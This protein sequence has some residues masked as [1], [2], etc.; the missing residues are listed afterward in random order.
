MDEVLKRFSLDELHRVKVVEVIL[1]GCPQVADRGDVW[2]AD[3]GG[4]SGFSQKAKP[5]RFI[6]KV[7][8]VD[9]FQSHGAA[10]ID[11]ERLVSDAHCTPTQFDRFAV[12][13]PR[14]FVMV[15]PLRWI[16]GYRLERIPGKR[17]FAG[18]NAT[19]K[20]LTKHAHRTEFHCPREFI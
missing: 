7:P 15:K 11:V 6:T 4:G 18:L 3:A 13:A 12:F 8:L 16:V 5:R 17:R 20:T 10:Q 1:S 19:G 9:D 14:Q 2:M